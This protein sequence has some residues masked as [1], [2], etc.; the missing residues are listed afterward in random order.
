MEPRVK[1]HRMHPGAF[2]YALKANTANRKPAPRHPGVAVCEC[3]AWSPELPSQI[4]RADWHRRHLVDV[5]AGK[6]QLL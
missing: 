6:T 3:G 4:D 1:G 5:I 2:A